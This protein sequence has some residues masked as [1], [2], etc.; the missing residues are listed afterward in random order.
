MNRNREVL[1]PKTRA[2]LKSLHQGIELEAQIGI[3]LHQFKAIPPASIATVS[4]QI[5]H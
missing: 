5:R 2:L 1:S 3:L 4:L